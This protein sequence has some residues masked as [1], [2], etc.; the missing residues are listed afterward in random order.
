V[1]SG[2]AHLPRVD[3]LRSRGMKTEMTESGH[4]LVCLATLG[5]GDVHQGAA[6]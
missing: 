6:T 3:K 1:L 2:Q 5:D 4:T